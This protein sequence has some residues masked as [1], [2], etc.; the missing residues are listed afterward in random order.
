MSADHEIKKPGQPVLLQVRTPCLQ[1]A[2][3]FTCAG[4]PPSSQN[5]L[6][7]S[8]SMTSTTSS[9]VTIPTR[10]SSWSIRQAWGNHNLV[11]AFRH[12]L[13]VVRSGHCLTSH[14]VFHDAAMT[15]SSAWVHQQV[16]TVTTPLQCPLCIHHIAGIYGL[17]IHPVLN[18]Q[19]PAPGF[20]HGPLFE[21]HVLRLS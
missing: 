1:V 21:S 13:L 10:R 17:L 2:W 16:L 7:A 4:W 12:L 8:C 3:L 5:P 6:V 14:G 18:R 20:G 15:S 9:T 19:M 11:E